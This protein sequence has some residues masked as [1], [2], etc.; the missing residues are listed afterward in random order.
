MDGLRAGLPVCHLVYQVMN[1]SIEY[2]MLRAYEMQQ[3]VPGLS[4]L[5]G[6]SI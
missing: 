3:V 4:Q 6:G 5:C 2:F 1:P